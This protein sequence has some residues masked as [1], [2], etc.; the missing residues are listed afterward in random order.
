[1]ERHGSGEQ[2]CYSIEEIWWQA[3]KSKK[4]HSSEEKVLEKLTEDDPYASTEVLVCRL[5]NKSVIEI[6]S[7][8][9]CRQLYS[10]ADE[11]FSYK[12]PI[13]L[14]AKTAW[15][16]SLTCRWDILKACT[17]QSTNPGIVHKSFT[18]QMNALFFC[19]PTMKR[20]L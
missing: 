7:R 4:K 18:S 15:R 8:T 2:R 17:M 14:A 3:E 6:G 16:K 11:R 10:R 12:T 13:N 9:V 20:L 1:M 19:C 5:L